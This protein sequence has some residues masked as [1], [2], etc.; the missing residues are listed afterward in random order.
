MTDD[1]PFDD[2]DPDAYRDREGDPFDDLGGEQTGE[3][4]DTDPDE[5]ETGDR[6]ATESDPFDYLGPDD[7]GRT[8]SQDSGQPDGPDSNQESRPV[9]VVTDPFSDVDVSRGDPFESTDTPFEREAVN[10]VDPD[11]VWE[12]FTADAE[13]VDTGDADSRENEDVVE[14]SKHSF[15]ERCPHFSSPPAVECGHDGTSILEFVGTEHV[16]VA[17]CPVVRER[18]ELGEVRE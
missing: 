13:S 2:I 16:R 11:E 7:A 14:V 15:C 1:D 18:R 3:E 10:G 6:Q 8:A 4:S 12:R 9:D 5:A 17:N